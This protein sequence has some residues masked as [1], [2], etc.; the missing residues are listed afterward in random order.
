MQNLGSRLK[1]YR[2]NIK[3]LTLDEF[4]AITGIPRSSIFEIEKGKHL[5]AGDKIEALIR[6]T[7]VNIYWLFTGEGPEIRT[8]LEAKDAWRRAWGDPILRGIIEALNGNQYAKMVV[9]EVIDLKGNYDRL[10]SRLKEYVEEKMKGELQS[11]RERE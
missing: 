10:L 7:D 3:N 11:E 2:K 6:A 4:S 8:S 1:H 9:A 5:P